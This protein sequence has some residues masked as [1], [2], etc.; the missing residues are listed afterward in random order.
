MSADTRHIRNLPAWQVVRRLK[1]AGVT[2]ETI[3]R[4]VRVSQPYVSHIIAR[5]HPRKPSPKSEQ[6]WNA[7]ERAVNGGPR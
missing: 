3:A 7:I 1:A 2:Q 6:V 4:E 5:R